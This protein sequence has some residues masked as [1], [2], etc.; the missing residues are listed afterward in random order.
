MTTWRKT[1]LSGLLIGAI[2][3]ASLL[4]GCG[5]GGPGGSTTGPNP[6]VKIEPPKDASGKEYKISEEGQLPGAK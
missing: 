6:E 2:G 5:G 4:P 3:L 1:G